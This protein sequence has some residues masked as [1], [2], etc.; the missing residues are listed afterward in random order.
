MLFAKKPGEPE[1]VKAKP[2]PEKAARKA[3]SLFVKKRED[4]PVDVE[5]HPVAEEPGIESAPST[6]HAAVSQPVSA[7]TD[8]FN[9]AHGAATAFEATQGPDK[10]DEAPVTEHDAPPK[11]ARGLFAKSKSREQAETDAAPAKRGIFGK[12]KTARRERSADEKGKPK[13]ARKRLWV[14]NAVTS[15]SPDEKPAQTKPAGK[16]SL[17]AGR[18][19]D[20][21]RKQPPRGTPIRSRR[22][23]APSSVIIQV[24]TERRRTTRWTVTAQG[25]VQLS[26]NTDSPVLV[27]SADDLRLKVTKRLTRG[28]AARVALT[29][30]GEPVRVVNQPKLRTVYARRIEQ[31]EAGTSLQPAQQVLDALLAARGL[32]LPVVTGFLLKDADGKPAV[33]LLYHYD[34]DGQSTSLQVSFAPEDLE[35][36]INQFI[37]SRKIARDGLEV[38]LFGNEDLLEYAGQAAAYPEAAAFLGLTASQASRGAVLVLS[39]ATLA[40]GA[41]I[42]VQMG[43]IGDFQRQTASARQKA[44]KVESATAQTIAESLGSFAS[45]YS[46]EPARGFELA[47]QTWRPGGLVTLVGTDAGFTLQLKVPLTNSRTFASRPSVE[48]TIAA[49]RLADLI[50]YTPAEGCTAQPLATSGNFSDVQI[51]V[52]CPTAHP[53]PA[54]YRLD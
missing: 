13:P 41:A 47:Q 4:V 31:F 30:V 27:F 2:V 28:A 51:T 6:A 43:Q 49:D 45:L 48:S 1:T 33:L 24:E 23:Q 8:D 22:G 25:C 35:F 34:G 26:D 10:A 32:T 12:S 18:F 17:L 16:M 5:A 39:A 50:A 11:V 54:R 37:S 14:R 7:P 20:S 15:Q 29:E 3:R 38:V 46:L 44:R 36:I 52:D 9:L 42:Y 21:K 40:F 53:G 19:T